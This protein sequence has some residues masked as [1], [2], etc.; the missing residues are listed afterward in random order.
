MCATTASGRCRVVDYG[1]RT[2]RCGVLTPSSAGSNTSYS[3]IS[4]SV[5]S[6]SSCAE[7]LH[8]YSSETAID[9]SDSLSLSVAMPVLLGRMK[10][11][12]AC[13]VCRTS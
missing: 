10:V 11:S 12:L 8:G 2:I 1:K 3:D 7:L 4:V 9:P 5:D 6:A 13:A